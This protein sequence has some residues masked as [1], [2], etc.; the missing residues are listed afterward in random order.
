MRCSQAFKRAL[1]IALATFATAFFLSFLFWPIPPRAEPIDGLTW[2]SS[3]SIDAPEEFDL[4]SVQ[5]EIQRSIDKLAESFPRDFRVLH[6]AGIVCSE[7]K[8]TANA[9]RMLRSSL[10]MKPS[11]NQIR[12]DLAQLLLLTG[13]DTEALQILEMGTEIGST[14]PDYVSL[15]AET[16]IRLGQLSE[17]TATLN[18]GL[19]RFQNSAKQ[20]RLLGELQLQ[21]GNYIDAESNLLSILRGNAIRQK[22]CGREPE[23]LHPTTIA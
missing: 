16:Q 9:K 14:Q 2:L 7:L 1:F 4:E 10:E 12:H 22:K 20:W 21:Q 19:K 18:A 5:E 8:Q 23:E 6:L 3:I 17:A 11:D 13:R 15:L